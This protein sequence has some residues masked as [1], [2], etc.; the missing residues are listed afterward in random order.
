M[1]LAS[2]I[3]AEAEKLET[4]VRNNSLPEPGF[5]ADVPDDFP[6]LPGD[7]QCSRQEIVYA[8]RELERLVHGPRESVRWGIWGYLDT[9]SL[10][11]INSYGLAKLVPLDSPIQL[12]ELQTKTTL[13]GVNLAR[14][15]QHAMTNRVFHEPAPGLIVHTAA[16]RLLAHDAALQ[17]WVGF[18]AE[19][20]FPAAGRVLTA[21]RAHP[22]AASATTTGF[23]YAFD[24]DGVE[25][26]FAT[27]ARDPA[28]AR[29][30]GGAMASL[31]GGESYELSHFVD[32][33]DLSDVD[34]R[35]GTLVDVGGSHGFVCVGLAQ[36]W[37]RM[38]FVV[39]D[40][41]MT[42]DSAPRPLC[43]DEAVAARIRLQAHDFFEEKPVQGADVY[44]FRWIIHNYSTLDAVRLLK[45]LVPALKPGARVI[46]DH[47][48]RQPGSENPWDERLMRSMELVM[49]MLLNAPEREEHE[50]RAL[51][52]AAD[53]HFV[54]KGF[55]RTEGC[56]MSIVEAVWD[57]QGEQVNGAPPECDGVYAE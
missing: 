35:A 24:A 37:P 14:V 32:N 47:C 43:D 42:V 21:L 7:V 52:E 23:N 8:T 9:L 12:S 28:R 39:Q 54:F 13:D 46:N 6:A 36:R 27:F 19:D 31:T 53:T 49:L 4:Y 30:M 26:M 17:D 51:F 22:E 45:K 38:R 56:R 25:P 57:P 2:R 15:L 33:Y 55:T 29:R 48:L 34:A 16:S 3:S 50:F 11:I 5:G 1:Q 44:F 20:V 10:Q 41:L 40:L 18:N